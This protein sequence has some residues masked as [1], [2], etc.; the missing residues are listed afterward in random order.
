M[1]ESLSYNSTSYMRSDDETTATQLQSILAWKG[2][3]ISLA[4]ILRNRHQLGWTYRGSA[5]CQL[6][7]P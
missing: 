2:I 5:Y 3:Y 6:I 7:R 4:T 1:F